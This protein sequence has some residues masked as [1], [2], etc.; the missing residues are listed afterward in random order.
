MTEQ[1]GMPHSALIEDVVVG[2]MR[3]DLTRPKW[4]ATMW[5]RI[6]IAGSVVAII[7]VAAAGMIA[8]NQAPVTQQ[9]IVHC[10]ATP[11]INSGGYDGTAVAISDGGQSVPINDALRVCRDVWASGAL[12]PGKDPLSA[13]QTTA[14][15]PESFT[16]CVMADGS[17][18]VIPGRIACSELHLHPLEH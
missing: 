7:G 13:E 17:A 10:F 16:A 15:V 3:E 1:R 6:S 8:L 12:A 14:A 4:W 2:Q 11:T 9:L 5:G 18:A